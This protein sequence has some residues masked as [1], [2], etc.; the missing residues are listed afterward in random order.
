MQEHSLKF[1]TLA[2]LGIKIFFVYIMLE[3]IFSNLSMAGCPVMCVNVGESELFSWEKSYFCPIF[4]GC[5]VLFSYF[6]DL[7]YYLTHCNRVV[8]QESILP[9]NIAL[10]FQHEHWDEQMEAGTFP[11]KI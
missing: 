9:L 6:F 8:D 2:S 1:F 7:S 5:N 11:G 3:S 10:L 4:W